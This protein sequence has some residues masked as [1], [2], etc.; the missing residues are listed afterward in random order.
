MS[1]TYTHFTQVIQRRV[2]SIQRLKM[3]DTDVLNGVNGK[4]TDFMEKTDVSK[5][6]G[7][8]TNSNRSTTPTC[9]S[10]KQFIM[11]NFSRKTI[12]TSITRSK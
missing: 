1:S 9:E 12:R 10:F 3:S 7:M 11:K 8:G 2:A 6:D 4:Y 5:V